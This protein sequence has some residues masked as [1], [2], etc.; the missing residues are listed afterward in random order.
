MRTWPED[1]ESA[2]A[3]V[4]AIAAATESRSPEQLL[5]ILEMVPERSPRRADV[6]L[7]GG[8]ALWREVLDK[9]RLEEGVRPADEVL[10]GWKQK[11]AQA[12]DEG[13]AAVPAGTPPARKTRT[14][15]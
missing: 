7:R 1:A 6:L 2:D 15:G 11:A 8:A 5:A 14:V 3:A 13:L 4:I 12:I 9:R 10:A